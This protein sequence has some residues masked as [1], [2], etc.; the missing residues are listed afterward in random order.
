METIRV[1]GSFFIAALL[2]IVMAFAHRLTGH[3]DDTVPLIAFFGVPWAWLTIHIW[4]FGT[5]PRWFNVILGFAALFWIPALLYPLIIR[6]FLWLVDFRAKPAPKHE[7]LKIAISLT[8]SM[9]VDTSLLHSSP[10]SMSDN[11]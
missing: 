1:R 11:A 3:P 6:G 4:D 9:T 8:R 10:G 5:P 2:T 7:A